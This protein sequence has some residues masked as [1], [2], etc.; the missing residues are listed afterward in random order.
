[1]PPLLCCART[2]LRRRNGPLSVPNELTAS[3]KSSAAKAV[4]WLKLCS[5]VVILSGP[6]GESAMAE[7]GKMITAGACCSYLNASRLLKYVGGDGLARQIWRKN[8]SLH[9]INEGFFARFNAARP[10]KVVFQQAAR[11]RLLAERN[12]NVFA[13]TLKRESR[14]AIHSQ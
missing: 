1:M 10:S 4:R 12:L 13:Q 14:H 8:R 3:I 7:N 6:A 9:E 2:R 11:A 5:T